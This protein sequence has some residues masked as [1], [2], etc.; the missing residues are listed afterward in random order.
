MGSAACVCVTPGAAAGAPS[1]ASQT[2]VCNM[3]WSK[4]VNELVTTH[5]Y[6]NNHIVIWRYPDMSKARGSDLLA[7]ACIVAS[8]V[9]T[10]LP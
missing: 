9:P 7:I 5:G 6:R 4:T 8:L 1:L 3:L 10:A 2:Q